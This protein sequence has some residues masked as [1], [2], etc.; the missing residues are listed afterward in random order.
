MRDFLEYVERSKEDSPNSLDFYME[1]FAA[2][3]KELD[4]LDPA[5]TFIIG[6][7]VGSG[8]DI[9]QN[10]SKIIG[11]LN[12]KEEIKSITDAITTLNLDED[13]GG[14]T[15]TSLRKAL[16]DDL[17]QLRAVLKSS[18]NEE[19]QPTLFDVNKYKK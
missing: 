3:L 11:L 5:K 15:I 13:K 10:K 4:G 16:T 2:D 18:K 1:G 14:V 17:V 19:N 7:L 12:Q 8:I 6:F 9:A